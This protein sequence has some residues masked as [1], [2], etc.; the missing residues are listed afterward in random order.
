LTFF[1]TELPPETFAFV[2][3]YE[4]R[5]QEPGQEPVEL[6]NAAFRRLDPFI[7]NP[8]ILLDRPLKLRFAEQVIEGPPKKGATSYQKKDPVSM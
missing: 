8:P 4:E 2:L 3:A 5:E 7:A 1:P 6:G